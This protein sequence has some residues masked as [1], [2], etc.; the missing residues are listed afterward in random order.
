[1]RKATTVIF[2]V[3]VLLVM[4]AFTAGTGA[5]VIYPAASIIRQPGVWIVLVSLLLAVLPGIFWGDEHITI[6]REAIRVLPDEAREWLGGEARALAEY[7]SLF[8][9]NNAPHQGRWGDEEGL[10]DAGYCPDFRR[11]WCVSYYCGWDSVLR[12]K[13]VTPRLN[14]ATCR[15]PLISRFPEWHEAECRY[16]PMGDYHT[17]RIYLPRCVRAIEEGNFADGMRFLGV[18][19]HHV[20]DR[21]AFHHWHDVHRVGH[22][23]D[24]G[25]I[26][27]AGYAP[28]L[29]G[30]NLQ[31]VIVA[32][33]S[34]MRALVAFEA[35]MI[36]ALRAARD[37]H[38][39]DEFDRLVLECA[40]ENCRVSAD[41][42]FSIAH[43]FDL[44]KYEPYSYYGYGDNP[45]GVN[46]VENGSFEVDDMT[47]C[48]DGWV[49]VRSDMMDH[50]GVAEWV[51]SRFS[52]IWVSVTRSG[53][54]AVK[55]MFSGRGLAWIQRWPYCI[56]VK[57]GDGYRLA[58]YI[59]AYK[60]TGRNCLRIH[61][62]RNDY[63]E[64]SMVEAPGILGT[65][66]WQ[67]SELDCKVPPEAGM[68]RIACYSEQNSGAVWFDDVE[69][70][71]L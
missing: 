59:K 9:D 3:G 19:L 12:G 55:M 35:P 45:V 34:R 60:A 50:A 17:P 43:L 37:S 32:I 23:L 28:V 16:W 13:P 8:P 14:T 64:V 57:P 10:P 56:S 25:M 36:P 62:Y 4:V 31:D 22:V 46:L 47:G 15:F 21:G 38:R 39:Q 27:I 1:M 30:E 29:L 61:F 18:L 11:E 68:M 41:I 52:S 65:R 24:Q 51:D 53:N 26:R 40:K 69:I 48:P 66:G 6:T 49:L 44:Q 33:Q 7:Y 70:V 63:S 54:H 2:I 42:I 58:G 20:Q 71:R 67:R 5:P